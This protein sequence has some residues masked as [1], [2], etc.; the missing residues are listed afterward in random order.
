MIAALL[1]ALQIRKLRSESGSSSGRLQTPFEP[2]TQWRQLKSLSK[3]GLEILAEGLRIDE[4]II[5]SS[6]QP[7]FKK[8]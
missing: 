4:G 3:G 5:C 6:L 2:Q 1:V 7:L 8:L